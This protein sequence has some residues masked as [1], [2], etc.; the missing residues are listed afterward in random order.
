MNTPGESAQVSPLISEPNSEDS[1]EH[2]PEPNPSP[3]EMAS[4][5]TLQDTVQSMFRSE[6]SATSEVEDIHSVASQSEKSLP[7]PLSPEENVQNATET[8]DTEGPG[9]SSQMSWGRKM[10]KEAGI[11]TYSPRCRVD[12]H[13]E[14]ECFAALIKQVKRKNSDNED[15]ELGK[16]K[17]EIKKKMTF[18]KFKRDLELVVIKGRSTD[19]LQYIM[20]VDN[21]LSV[22][23]LYLLSVFGDFARSHSAEGH[24]MGV[25]AEVMDLWAH[26]SSEG[27]SKISA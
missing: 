17:A 20:E 25:N 10:D 15:S 26:Y 19:G 9:D 16:F 18:K 5:P 7:S 2:I 27:L 8:K 3:E 4:T 21:S 6:Y 22:F 14:E 24:Q 12:S 1:D 11:K 23:A 13:S